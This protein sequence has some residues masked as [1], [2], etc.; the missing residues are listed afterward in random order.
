MFGYSMVQTVRS[1]AHKLDK[2]LR[3]QML[4]M[5]K[6]FKWTP[7]FFH[8]VF[9]KML[10]KRKTYSVIVELN[11]GCF[12]QG[13]MT[14][15]HVLKKH[16][17]CQLRHSFSK[18]RCVSANVTPES[19]QEMLVC[20]DIRKIYL[21]REVHALL[22]TAVESAQA[23]EVIRNGETLTGKDVTIAVIDTGIYPHE[24]LEG[25]IKAFVD[26][27]NQREEPYDDN[28]HG[29]HCAGDAAGNGA[30]SD[31]QY[32]G[33]AP[34]ANVI[35][36]KV[37]N[38]QGMGSLESIMQGVEWCIQY[39]EKHPDDPIHIISMSLGGQALPYENEQEDP[40]VRIV[41]EAWNAGITVCVAAGN[42][43]P[44]AQT[45]ASPGV[46]EK[47]ITVGALDDRD[48][49][50]REDDDVAPFSS[51][52][53]TIYGKP[54][55][56]ILAPGV[57]IVSLRSPNSFYD[58]IQKGSRVGSHY[59]MMSGTSM[60]TPVCA[61]VVALMLQHEPNLTPDEVKTRLMEGTDRWADR[62]PNVYGAGY[63]S[64]EGAIPN[65]EEE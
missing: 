17:K 39:N 19:L 56:D 52:G 2:P 8:S 40:M 26:F 50:D 63:I 23:F 55:P 10:L 9:E 4:S 35:G 44:D 45:I 6:P 11:Q 24:D 29:T 3:E 48:T 42:S 38:K 22:D 25:R 58:K 12:D 31:G 18:I 36:V 37:L 54:K 57:N 15:E 33:P 13:S 53:P 62:D 5:Y 1:N 43:G 7:C 49:T 64:A 21:N 60:A 41:E 14:V 30:S 47:V 28:G 27:V 32:R 51:R 61:G 46:S 34:E 16:Q 59:T 65:S 20:K